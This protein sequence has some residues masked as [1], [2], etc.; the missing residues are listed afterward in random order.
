[1]RLDQHKINKQHYQIML[2]IFIG[3]SLASWALRQ[4]HPFPE[5][6]VIGFAVGCVQVLDW[7]AAST[8][9]QSLERNNSHDSSYSMQIGIG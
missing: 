2:D 8:F 7:E 3:K 4:P 9:Y 5:R 6:L 1:L